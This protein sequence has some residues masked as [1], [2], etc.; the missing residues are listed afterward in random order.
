MSHTRST[1]R[2][3]RPSED[4]VSLKNR[5]LY[6]SS[7]L[8]L[9]VL[10]FVGG[11]FGLDDA[12][13]QDNRSALQ[14]AE[15]GADFSACPSPELDFDDYKLRLDQCLRATNLILPGNRFVSLRAASTD[16]QILVLSN[17]TSSVSVRVQD[18]IYPTLERALSEHPDLLYVIH[19]AIQDQLDKPSQRHVADTALAAK[20][21]HQIF[22]GFAVHAAAMPPLSNIDLASQ[23]D[24]AGATADNRAADAVADEGSGKHKPQS[25][26]STS[27]RGLSGSVLTGTAAVVAVAALAGGGG[28]GGGGGGASGDN[29]GAGSGGPAGSVTAHPLD[30]GTD[31]VYSATAA[32]M[33]SQSL[34]FM[35][36]NFSTTQ[37]NPLAT[38]NAHKATG[39]GLTG[40][41]LSVQIVDSC[42][43]PDHQDLASTTITTFGD[44]SNCAFSDVHGA[45]VGGI[46]AG[47]FNNT[48]LVGIATDTSLEY[49]DTGNNT[50]QD[51]ASA[52][53]RLDKLAAATDASQA[54]VQNNSWLLVT[55]AR[56]CPAPNT[57][58]QL[59]YE[60]VKARTDDGETVT[61]AYTNLITLS[62]WARADGT[63]VDNY[64][65]ALND[66]QEHGAIVYALSNY[67]LDDEAHALAALPEFYAQLQEAWITVANVNV[68]R[69]ARRNIYT[70]RS[71][72]CG[73]TAR[74]CLATDGYEI[75]T[76]GTGV[77]GYKTDMSG[78]SFS[79][80]MVSAALVLL[81]QAF[82]THTPEQLVDRLLASA[83][84]DWEDG[85]FIAEDYV[86]FGNGVRHYYNR[87]FGHGMLDIYAALQ[88]IIANGT[89]AQN[90]S[91]YSGASRLGD[92]GYGLTATGMQTS[93]PFGDTMSRAFAGQVNYFYDD[94]NGAFAYDLSTHISA[95][96][97]RDVSLD[98]SSEMKT[99]RAF[100]LDHEQASSLVYSG[101]LGL[102]AA[103]SQQV[104][105][106]LRPIVGD[107]DQPIRDFLSLGSKLVRGFTRYDTPYLMSE[108]NGQGVNATMDLE[109]AHI[110]FSYNRTNEDPDDAAMSFGQ[111]NGA[112]RQ[113]KSAGLHT[114]TYNRQSGT[115]ATFAYMGAKTMHKQLVDNE[116]KVH[117]TSLM[118]GA[119]YYP[120]EH[121]GLGFIAGRAQEKNGFL[122]MTGSGALDFQDAMSFTD[123]YGFNFGYQIS[124][125]LALRGRAS[126]SDTNMELEA[127]RIIRG[128]DNVEANSFSLELETHN[129][130]GNDIASLSI[131]QPSRV[132]D[133]RIDILLSDRA[134]QD[135]KITYRDET[136]NL[137]PSGRQ[138]DLSL[139]YAKHLSA[140]MSA[141]FKFTQTDDIHHIAGA[142]KTYSG[143]L[144]FQYKDLAFGVGQQRADSELRMSYVKRF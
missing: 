47:N 78:T 50:L 65:R 101:G 128:A 22:S 13:G 43:N 54:V 52:D 60:A 102:N 26:P 24:P 105:L 127:D 19:A 92:D 64:V 97:L 72:Q 7:K 57:G 33:R 123:F 118:V 6:K 122:G 71:S 82:P 45:A 17:Q 77:D 124:D 144:G 48:G 86:V 89:G 37:P 88:P 110:F 117:K 56:N 131:S 91:I 68:S 30:A 115:H 135:G 108:E 96:N 62:N 143:F 126:V 9:V 63:S 12:H 104:S 4:Y 15:Q 3:S 21:K 136:L 5:W 95:S 141:S 59:G 138:I 106:R 23:P 99:L 85:Q 111:T 116:T 53:Y 27:K 1:R 73:V 75:N 103:D 90:L 46:I 2:V 134:D 76:L 28:G 109:N 93:S 36:T 98:L 125:L 44:V 139:T 133:G 14:G 142:A 80:P 140:E 38:I 35:D 32:N 55:T 8:C 18:K 11:A 70:R 120:T 132:Y 112:E 10:I 121:F 84:N 20:I 25:A 66:F 79:T 83:N 129:L 49:T 61:G 74:Y 113:A 29:S 119:K 40:A 58:C 16:V 107:T 94:M 31:R 42:Y 41:G 51:D 81:K 130:F 69:S 87:E 34:E 114:Y 67:M 100:A 39:Y 137:S